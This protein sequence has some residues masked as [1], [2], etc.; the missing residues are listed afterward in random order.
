MDADAP[1]IDD[2]I[3]A[4]FEPFLGAPMAVAVSGGADSMAL[5]HIAQRALAL[6]PPLAPAMPDRPRLIVLTVD[7]GLR[8]DSADDAAWVVSQAEA[9]G[10][11]CHVVRWKGEKP[12]QGIQAAARAA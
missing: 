3:R 12:S 2:E 1:I 6:V 10:L 5:M 4:R 9:A 11:P 8:P 7:H